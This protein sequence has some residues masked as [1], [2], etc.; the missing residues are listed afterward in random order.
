MHSLLLKLL[1]I[2][3]LKTESPHLVGRA[4]PDAAGQTRPFGK[5]L[6]NLN[7]FKA[8]KKKKKQKGGTLAAICSIL[9]RKSLRSV[10]KQPSISPISC[11][12][13]APTGRRFCVSA[14]ALASPTRPGSREGQYSEP[15]NA[16]I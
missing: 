4:T 13:A 5:N 11:A 15:S 16:P 3:Y 7:F 9:A 6:S 12:S 8:N 14:A 2:T 1:R 10:P